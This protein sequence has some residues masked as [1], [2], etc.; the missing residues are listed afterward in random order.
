MKQTNKQLT[1]LCHT[2]DQAQSAA[3]SNVAL[4]KSYRKSLLAKFYRAKA[5][6]IQAP[7]AVFAGVAD[8]HDVVQSK[9]QERFGRGTGAVSKPISEGSPRRWTKSKRGRTLACGRGS[10][11][12][13]CSDAAGCHIYNAETLSV[14]IASV[15]EETDESMANPRFHG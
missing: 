12:H 4:A 13:A 8:G 10:W 5:T 7:E 6:P 1:L 9:P 2:R 11:G 3:L 15:I 14:C